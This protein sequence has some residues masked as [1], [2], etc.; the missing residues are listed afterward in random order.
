MTLIAL[1]MLTS[2]LTVTAA[3][4]DDGRGNDNTQIFWVYGTLVDNP[5]MPL[6]HKPA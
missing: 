5:G 1:G 3:S 4:Y 2:M 6:H